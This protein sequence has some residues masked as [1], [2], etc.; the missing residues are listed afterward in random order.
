MIVW[1]GSILI[2]QQFGED[3]LVPL[4][5]MQPTLD[6][7]AR[8]SLWRADVGR[9]YPFANELPILGG[10]THTAIWKEYADDMARMTPV[11]CGALD[12][13]LRATGV[14]EGSHRFGA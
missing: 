14:P 13:H 10:L 1:L 6:L 12:R 11:L 8:D 4:E 5:H 3:H 7:D 2:F 9:D